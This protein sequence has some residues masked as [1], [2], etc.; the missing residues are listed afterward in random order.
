LERQ[1]RESELDATSRDKEA[2]EN[3]D[4]DAALSVKK[5]SPVHLSDKPSNKLTEDEGSKFDAKLLDSIA[6][7]RESSLSLHS[8]KTVSE[9]TK[10]D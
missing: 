3:K 7:P 6:E 2:F 8:P 10:L 5:D 4:N 9:N 1:R